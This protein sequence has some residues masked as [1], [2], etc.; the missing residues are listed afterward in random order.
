MD[1]SAQSA[2]LAAL[3]AVGLSPHGDDEEKLAE[4]A[5]G[6]TAENFWRHPDAHPVVLDFQLLK[7]YGAEW[8]TWEP[9]TLEL[10]IPKDFGAQSLS[11][12]NLAKIQACKTLHLVDS[13]WQRWEVFVWCTMALNGVFPDFDIMQVPTVAQCMVS[14]DIADHIRKDLRF[15]E[16]VRT[17]LDALHRHEGVLV[18]LAPLTFVNVDTREIHVD[19]DAIKKRWPDVQGKPV[20]GDTM[21]DEQLRRMLI[22]KHFLEESRT[23]LRQQMRLVAHA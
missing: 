3:Q 16:E 20:T 11:D 5:L 23:R 8:L 13:F 14:V 1:T 19:V 12:L 7:K 6:V 18:P 9:E 10:Q 17:Y 22:S 21:E 15:T 2:F 4:E